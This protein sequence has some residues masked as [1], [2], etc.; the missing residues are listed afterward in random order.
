MAYETHETEEAPQVMK[1]TRA[2]QGSWGRHIFWVL[3]ISIVLAA[4]ALFGSWAFNAPN[5]QGEG[6]WTRNTSDA[7]PMFDAPEPA[8][9]IPDA[10]REAPYPKS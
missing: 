10:A 5:L 1:A 7:P 9:K 6:G 2:R 3:I 8:P 4:L